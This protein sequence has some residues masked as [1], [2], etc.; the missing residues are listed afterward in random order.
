MVVR[1]IYPV[2]SQQFSFSCPIFSY[3]LANQTA[4]VQSKLIQTCKYFFIKNSILVVDECGCNETNVWLTIKQ[5]GKKCSLNLQELSYKIW[6][7]SSFFCN[8]ST[9]TFF[10]NIYHYKNG[11]FYFFNEKIQLLTYG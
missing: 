9:S 5:N 3:I 2:S 6:I 11:Q 1:S 7:T 4:I 10:S 8:T